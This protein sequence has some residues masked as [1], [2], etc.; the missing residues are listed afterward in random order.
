[1]AT[2]VEKINGNAQTAANGLVYNATLTDAGLINMHVKNYSGVEF[3]LTTAG[4][5]FNSIP[6]DG[7]NNAAFVVPAGTL[8]A[9]SGD[10][11][12]ESTDGTDATIDIVDTGA[13]NDLVAAGTSASSSGGTVNGLDAGDLVINGTAIGAAIPSNDVASST[14]TSDGFTIISSSKSRSAIAVAAAINLASDATGVTASADPTIVNGG[15]GSNADVTKY[16]VNDTA[17]LYINGVDLGTLTLQDDGAGVVSEDDARLNA[18][19]MINAASGQTGVTAVDNGASLTLTAADGRNVS[20]AIDNQTTGSVTGLVAAPDADSDTKTSSIGA[21]FGLDGAVSGIG[22]QRF[23]AY[24]TPATLTGLVVGQTA[25]A[26]VYETTYGSIKL[27]SA[28]AITVSSGS[29]GSDEVEALGMT[30]GSYGNGTDGTFLKDVDI[31]TFQGAQDAMTALDNALDS[32]SAQRSELGAMQNRFE[33]T[34]SNLQIASEN[35]SAA[36]SRIR[37]AD[38]AT[39]TAELSRT[40]VLQQA[41]I[42]ILAQA[43]QRPQQVLSLLG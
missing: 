35:L 7:A 33:S 31:S 3:S 34:S 11:H 21:I 10:L 23:A 5:T 42:S 18:M 14:T 15:D 39:E 2:I 13:G 9:M 16:A 38:F 20:I 29:N 6:L 27:D 24:S 40:Q 22:E 19:D 43:N 41:G 17:Q 32:I 36:N 25:E 26:M 37:D 4:A 1:N 28:S 30:I 12:Y 8:T